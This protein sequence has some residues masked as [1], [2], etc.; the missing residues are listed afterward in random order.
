MQMYDD[1]RNVWVEVDDPPIDHSQNPLIGIAL[2][3]LVLWLAY[4]MS[5]SPAIIWTGV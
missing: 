3:A 5:G 4:V 2:L 1:D